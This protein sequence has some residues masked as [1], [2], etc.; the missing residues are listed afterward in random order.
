MSWAILGN[1]EIYKEYVNNISDSRNLA[2]SDDIS[3]TPCI[4]GI[5]YSNIN[6]SLFIHNPLKNILDIIHN[7][8][9]NDYVD[10]KTSAPVREKA[11]ELLRY[12]PLTME[13]IEDVMRMIGDEVQFS[14]LL[15]MTF[16]EIA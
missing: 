5:R 4:I 8:K 9:F 16:F 6:S 14:G 7:D 15:S 11:A 12:C 2:V 13:A 3:H 1:I 10:D